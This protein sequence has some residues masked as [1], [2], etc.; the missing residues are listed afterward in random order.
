[1][2]DR[3]LEFDF[4]C[5]Y[6]I[7]YICRSFEDAEA[8]VESSTR[9]VE[10]AEENIRTERNTKQSD[11]EI[12]ETSLLAPVDHCNREEHV[13]VEAGR[14]GRHAGGH[15]GE[16]KDGE[17]EATVEMNFVDEHSSI[18]QSS[19][20]TIVRKFLKTDKGGLKE[21]T[22]HH[23]EDTMQEDHNEE[24]MQGDHLLK[25]FNW[26]V[27]GAICATVLGASGEE[28]SKQRRDQ[29]EVLITRRLKEESRNLSSALELKLTPRILG[30]MRQQLDE[31]TYVDPKEPNPESKAKVE[32]PLVDQKSLIKENEETER[33]VDCN[34]SLSMKKSK[35]VKKTN[36]KKMRQKGPTKVEA[37]KEEGELDTSSDAEGIASFVESCQNLLGSRR[38]DKNAFSQGLS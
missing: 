18:S 3:D 28:G 24:T 13:K 19:E 5:R 16:K 6:K 12:I 34:S 23:N 15:D 27:A 26:Q 30:I 9:T 1:M 2:R 21:D 11:K 33:G 20:S 4:F 25:I 36:T 8:D 17:G 7:G 31:W 37:I 29:L 14:A 35:V 32:W 22:M 38:K 10:S